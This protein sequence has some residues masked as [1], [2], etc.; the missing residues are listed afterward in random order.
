MR[1]KK[2]RI[3][4]ILYLPIT[5]LGGSALYVIIFLDVFGF[6]F[7]LAKLGVKRAQDILE[8]LRDLV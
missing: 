7:V 8:K 2:K 4:P 1:H 5:L 3:P 6:K